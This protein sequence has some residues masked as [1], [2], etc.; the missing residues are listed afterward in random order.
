MSRTERGVE[1]RSD[2]RRFPTPVATLF[3]DALEHNIALMSDH[4][5]VADVDLAPHAKTT[6]SVDVVSRQLA[7]G[8]W[9]VTV[10]TPRQARA[11]ASTSPPRILVAN[12]IVD[13]VEL[14]WLQE[15]T[16]SGQA[17][18]CFVDSV[19]GA[20]VM[21]EHLSRA[22]R[23]VPV[24]IELG[25]F[26]G[27][28]GCRT[29]DDALAVYDVIADNSSALRLAGVAGFEGLAGDRSDPHAAQ[30]VRELMALMRESAIALMH[31]DAR[32][33]DTSPFILSAGGSAFFDLV[34]IGLHSRKHDY[35]RPTR[36]VLRSGCYAIHDHGAY[37]DNTPFSHGSGFI[38]ALRVWSRVLSTPEADLAIIDAGRRDVSFDAGLPKVLAT[39]SIDWEPREGDVSG[40]EVVGLNDQHGY[41]AGA[42][43]SLQVGD[44]V[45]LGISHPCTTFDRWRTMPLLSAELS[46]VGTATMQF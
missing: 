34:E 42:S 27:R 40:L 5:L 26:Q 33:A 43:T 25:L 38:P 2:L 23:P 39:Y 8:A 41:L 13:P 16:E 24:L 37:S 4:C 7:A 18:Y 28:A 1:F 15:T 45:E 22:A 10:A 21:A 29:V 19:R 36:V 3:V 32:A 14:S 11:I 17:V 30:R 35:P 9:G 20:T 12:Q 6:M 46:V 44:V 31:R